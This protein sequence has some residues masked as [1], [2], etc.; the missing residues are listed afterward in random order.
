M[1]RLVIRATLASFALAAFGS[2]SYLF[3][4]A[5]SA[6]ASS[7]AASAQPVDHAESYFHYGMAKLYENEAVASG[8]QD[9]ASQA[10]EQYKLALDADPN[11]R[12]LQDGVANLYF[13]LGRIREAVAAAE[14]QINKHPDDIDAH[15]LLG[16]VYLRSIGDGQGPETEQMLQAA[17]K[18]YQTIVSLK[19]GDLENQLLLGQLYSLNHQPLKAEEQY[20]I[21]QKIDPTNE[22][23]VLDI[24]R[25]Y[26]EEGD[27]NQA[28]DVIAKVPLSDRTARMDFA[29]AGLYDQLK[30]PK[31]AAKAYQDALDQDPGNTNAERGLAAAL[32]RAGETAEAA[33]V[34]A[35]ILASNPDDPQALMREGEL[36]RQKGEFEQ[37]LATFKKVQAQ[38]P[39]ENDPELIYNEALTYDGLGRF[40]ESIKAVKLLLSVTAA[41]DGKY[42]GDAEQNRAALL[43]LLGRVAGQ[44]GDEDEAIAA[45]QQMAALGGGFAAQATDSEVDIYR[46]AHQWTKALQVSADAAKTMPSNHD[47]QLTYA[48]QLADAGKLAEAVK[49]ARAQLTGTPDDRDVYYD[50][51]EMYVRAKRWKDASHAFDKAAVLATQPDDKVILYYFR[52][53]AE[54][55]EKSYDQA[56]ADFQKGLAISPNNAS[57]ENDLGYMYAD[58]GIK[59]DQAVE[60]LKK[61]V[62]SD[63][64]NY[65][66]LDSLAWAYYKQGMYALAQNYSRK[67]VKLMPNDPTVLAHLG[68]IE[69]KNGKLQEAIDD[70]QRSL[71]EF[72]TSLPPDIDPADVANV[73]H[74]LESARVRLAHLGEAPAK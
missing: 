33:K 55:R 49:L 7:A 6:P 52:G 12:I 61:A 29:L 37:A 24:A 70:W 53:D 66:F 32:A 18:E 71:Q 20:K 62:A 16:H 51:A 44:A 64:Q 8:R 28:A 50:L 30:R 65:A 60:M 39:N 69:A 10:I 26:S 27:L 59:L 34:N 2:P 14:D 68:A 56:E 41:P 25:Q 9:L 21:A 74:E 15:L 73:R 4:Q 19:P 40:P 63:P 42:S 11:S 72:A 1:S 17:I 57:I 23:V 58:R 67:A 22:D 45:Y 13:R 48:L 5:S 3:A 38:I 54:L 35:E 46:D 36:E 47:V 43:Q 31:D